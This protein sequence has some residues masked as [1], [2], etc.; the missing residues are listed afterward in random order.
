MSQ[1]FII[2]QIGNPELDTVYEEV[3]VPALK[4]CGLEAKRVDKELVETFYACCSIFQKN[5]LCIR[6][7]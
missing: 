5:V 4:A 1:A 3:F 7:E 2:M 6:D